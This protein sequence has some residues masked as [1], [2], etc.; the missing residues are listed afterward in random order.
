MRAQRIFEALAITFPVSVSASEQEDHLKTWLQTSHFHFV[1][2]KQ[3]VQPNN[4]QDK[5]S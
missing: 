2:F 3:I 4:L 5:H 1:S